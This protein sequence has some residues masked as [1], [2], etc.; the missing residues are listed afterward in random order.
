MPLK[1]YLVE[2]CPVTRDHVA[3]TL[4]EQAGARVVGWAS[5]EQD[6]CQ[7]LAKNAAGWDLIV[8]DLFLAQGSGM[9]VLKACRC[10]RPDQRVVVMSSYITRAIHQR[11]LTL[12]ADA[13]FD[14]AIDM[15][16]LVQSTRAH[17]GLRSLA[18]P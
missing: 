1:T 15:E 16:S 8:I 11:C 13:V 4:E 6:A 5:T 9:N 12:G 3:D 10:R 2:D 18:T 17:A 14:K 7:W